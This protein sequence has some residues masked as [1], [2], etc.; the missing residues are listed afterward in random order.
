MRQ[1]SKHSTRPSFVRSAALLG[2]TLGF[3]LAGGTSPTGRGLEL[4]RSAEARPMRHPV[5]HALM[6]DLTWIEAMNGERDDLRAGNRIENH[7]A[8]V[9][10]GLLQSLARQQP[11]YVTLQQTL[12][13]LYAMAAINARAIEADPEVSQRVAGAIEHMRARTEQVL[14][15]IGAYAAPPRPA[16]YRVPVV[17]APPVVVPLPQNYQQQYQANVPPPPPGQ[18]QQTPPP[19]PGQWQQTPPPPPPGQWQQQQQGQW[20]QQPPPPPGQWQQTPPGYPAPAPVPVVAPMAP[21][22][23]GGALAQMQRLSF[24][25]E[26]VNY[27]RDLV[28]SG[29]YFTCDQIAQLMR[30]A[31]FGDDQV[32]IAAMLYKNAVDPQNFTALTTT[33]TF[34]SD[35][36]K[37]RRMLGR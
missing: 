11:L 21:A 9:R 5:M 13:Q 6:Q 15:R 2:L 14:T 22:A 33:L 3:T 26:K 35:R 16:D 7:V 1:P 20:Q 29:N 27:A 36:Q 28:S 34:E 24:S 17:I 19:P 4:V 12:N 30:T 18:W 31:S 10:Q 25:D 37:L 23:F 8:T 32:K